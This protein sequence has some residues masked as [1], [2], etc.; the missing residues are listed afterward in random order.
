[1]RQTE[2]STVAVADAQYWNEQHMDDVTAEHGIQVLIPP[3]S[4]KREGERPGWT[5]GRYSF[6][7]RVLVTELGKQLYRKRQ[8][9][10]EPVYG[11]TKHNRRFDRIN[12]RGRRAIR[13]EWRLIT[14]SHNL[15]KLHRH[16]IVALGA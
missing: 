3:D 6:M 12:Y 7:R 5:G 1:V 8:R 2:K 16:Q 13:T 11:H 10:I 4:G 15:T 9:S 14:M